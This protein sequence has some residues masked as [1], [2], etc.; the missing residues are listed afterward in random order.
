MTSEGPFQTR[1]FCIK[2]PAEDAA[3]QVAETLS[4]H[5]L[6]GS[7]FSGKRNLSIILI[8]CERSAHSLHDP[9]PLHVLGSSSAQAALG[10]SAGN[11]IP[12]L[13]T[14]KAIKKLNQTFS[15]YTFREQPAVLACYSIT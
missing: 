14:H 3:P 9:A 13:S 2:P 1:L 7:F 15:G 10:K 11:A 4:Q 6:E 8:L 12:P 5:I